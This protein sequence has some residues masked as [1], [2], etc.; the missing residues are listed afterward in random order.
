MSAY[1]QFRAATPRVTRVEM[2]NLYVGDDT[3]AVQLDAIPCETWIQNLRGLVSQCPELSGA[4]LEIEGLWV[5]F[6][7]LGKGV[8]PVAPHLLEL[9]AAAGEMAYAPALV[10]SSSLDSPGAFARR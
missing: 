5:H 6:T 4:R 3:T 10:P 7:G 2:A 9:I 1:P 8:R